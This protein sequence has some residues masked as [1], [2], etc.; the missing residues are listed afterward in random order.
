MTRSY[1]AVTAAI[2]SATIDGVNDAVTLELLG[3]KSA[4]FWLKDAATLSGLTLVPELRFGDVWVTG[5]MHVTNQTTAAPIVVS[6]TL[7]AVPAY[8]FHV[9]GQGADAVRLRA[10]AISGGSVTLLGR[11]SDDESVPR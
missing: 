6:A 5:A 7:A 8:A 3:A 2:E 10:S 9:P 4:Q 11:V 1:G